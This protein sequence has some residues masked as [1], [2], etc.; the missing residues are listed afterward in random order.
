MVFPSKSRRTGGWSAKLK[1]L[2]SWSTPWQGPYLRGH[3]EGDYE[4]LEKA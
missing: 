3:K 4:G 1:R 2:I